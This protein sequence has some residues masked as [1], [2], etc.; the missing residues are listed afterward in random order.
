MRLF[1][2]DNRISTAVK[3]KTGSILQVYPVKVTFSDEVAWQKHWDEALKPKII[4]RIGYPDDKKVASTA[5][6]AASSAPTGQAVTREL[7][8]TAVTRAKTSA[9]KLSF[10]DWTTELKDN[11]GFS[12]PA[13]RYYIGDLCY[14][15]SD[16]V[17]DTIFGGT[18]YDTGI[19]TDKRSGSVFAMSHTAYG[20][21]LYPSSDGKQFAVD[22]GIIGICSESL[23][24]K[25]CN[26]GHIYTF[27]KP[28]SCKF[29]DGCFSFNWGYKSLV[30]DTTGND[31]AY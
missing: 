27:D 7:V 8:Q 1:V 22:A 6:P 17:Y 11:F 31:D 3:T 19:Y 20:D 23:I 16:D 26:G 28:L 9:P 10:A 30:I 25:S 4:L 13:G 18:G 29:K 24:A 2:N 5:S 12:L 15:L 14:A 21:G